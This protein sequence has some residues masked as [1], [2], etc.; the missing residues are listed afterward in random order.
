MDLETL[1]VK[2]LATNRLSEELTTTAFAAD[3]VAE[4]M[5]DGA[6]AGSELAA[7]MSWSESEA[8]SLTRQL[9]AAN[10]ELAE[11]AAEGA[12][13][14]EGMGEVAQEQAE[15]SA[16]AAMLEQRID[17]VGDEA[18][19]S[20]AQ[21]QAFGSAT[22]SAADSQLRANLAGISGSLARI[23]T[24]AAAATPPLLAMGAGLT[25]IAGF[26]GAGAAGALGFT[27]A[28]IQSRAEEMARFSEELETAADAREQLMEGF[29]GQLES[30]TDALQTPAAEQFAIAN[31]QALVD[32]VG[33]ASDALAAVQPTIFAVAGGLREAFVATSPEL[34]GELAA[35]TEQLAPLFLE[36]QGTIR[37]LPGLIAFL[38]DATQ[39]IGSDILVFGS[40]LVEVGAGATEV[41]L[42]VSDVL[43]PPLSGLLFLAGGVLSIFEALPGPIQN[44]AAAFALIGGVAYVAAGGLGVY[45]A[46]SSV[47]ATATTALTT[48]VAVLGGVLSLPIWAIAALGAGAV[49]LASHF[50]LL[51]DATGLVV[52]T[53]NELVDIAE[54]AVNGVLWLSESLY[55]LLGPLALLI[56]GLGPAIVFLGNLDAIVRETGEGIDW[57]KKQ[58]RELAAWAGKYLGPVIDAYDRLKERASEE[59]GVDLGAAEIGGGDS[60]DSGD[61]GS[62]GGGGSD[63]RPPT[64]PS[65][66]APTTGSGSDGVTVDMSGSEFGG[67]TSESDVK[68]W[69]KEGV[70]E[71]NRQ[72]RRREDAQ[73]G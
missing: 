13:Y 37:R 54:L 45:A 62:S 11:G 66:G 51:D 21:M 26:G 50:G 48:S 47:A 9:G 6:V 2:L 61:D 39:R 55:D 43:L 30:A 40:A 57:L 67:S 53:W 49:A 25:G 18:L 42:A 63:G 22:D 34:F 7:G 59:G 19:T 69:V 32:V 8:S 14:A 35:Q 31:M 52:D 24:V 44:A 28:G 56:P 29:M 5:Q 60:D 27:A 23:G 12:I 64:P 20:A 3:R 38:G 33:E 71:A 65:A 4:S 1:K 70:K 41:G 36:L 46:A 16:T 15:A 68:R 58:I 10:S 73:G 72:S 17:E